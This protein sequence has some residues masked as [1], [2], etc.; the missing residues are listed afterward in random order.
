MS[1]ESG[2]MIMSEPKNNEY[3]QPQHKNPNVRGAGLA[4]YILHKYTCALGDVRVLVGPA[5]FSIDR[6]WRFSG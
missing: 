3:E 4:P 2:F 6:V 5:S 1:H